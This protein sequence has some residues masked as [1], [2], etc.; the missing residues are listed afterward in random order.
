MSLVTKNEE[1]EASKIELGPP[2]ISRELQR[3]SS[4]EREIEVAYAFDKTPPWFT[5]SLRY[6]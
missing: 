2:L 6:T 5:Q 1:S 4:E 3:L